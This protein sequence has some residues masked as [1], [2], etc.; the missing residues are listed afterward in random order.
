M[1]TIY[2]LIVLSAI[3]TVL[4]SCNRNTKTEPAIYEFEVYKT[5]EIVVDDT[6]IDSSYIYAVPKQLLDINGKDVLV[7]MSDDKTQSFYDLET[8]RKL[9]EINNVE[10]EE[11]KFLDTVITVDAPL[12]SG[13]SKELGVTLKYDN[14]NDIYWAI[15]TLE[16]NISDGCIRE[17]LIIDKNFDYLGLIFNDEKS[18]WFSNGRILIDIVPVEKTKM[19]V[20]FMKLKKTDRDYKQYVDSCRTIVEKT[21]QDYEK[22]KI[23][24]DTEDII[25]TDVEPSN[26]HLINVKNVI[27]DFVL[28]CLRWRIDSYSLL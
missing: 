8:G 12:V 21:Q 14:T 2:W 11:N 23:A 10:L 6:D 18:P 20:N 4:V 17:L 9:S 25:Q 16:C 27:R 3:M 26:P 28:S 22:S 15:K 24:S 13:D 7:F 1:R 5:Q 19:K